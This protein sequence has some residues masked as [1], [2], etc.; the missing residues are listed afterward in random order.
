MYI[1]IYYQIVH[2]VHKRVIRLLTSAKS[3]R[4]ERDIQPF[5][6][7][8]NSSTAL[9]AATTR[10]SGPKFTNDLRTIL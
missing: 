8:I 7:K 9:P 6:T 10:R 3:R 1:Y 4:N 5:L 2:E